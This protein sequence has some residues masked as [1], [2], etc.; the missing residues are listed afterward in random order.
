MSDKEK[1]EC[2]K[3]NLGH[4]FTFDFQ[5][6]LIQRA[7]CFDNT[8]EENLLKYYKLFLAE[9]Y[10]A[11]ERDTTCNKNTKNAIEDYLQEDEV[12]AEPNGITTYFGN[13][14][15][16]YKFWVSLMG[17]EAFEKIK[18]VMRSGE[19]TEAFM[20]DVKY[21]KIVRADYDDDDS[22]FYR[23]RYSKSRLKKA[24]MFHIPFK[25]AYR[26]KNQRF[27]LTGL[28]L[29]YLANTPQTVAYE[30]ESEQEECTFTDLYVS[31][32]KFCGNPEKKVLNMLDLRIQLTDSNHE[33]YNIYD[34]NSECQFK[35]YIERFILSCVCSFPA[36]HRNENFVEEYVIPQLVTQEVK[37]STKCDG[38]CYNSALHN[39][40]SCVNF[41]LFTQRSSDTGVDEELRRLFEITNPVT[42]RD[43]LPGCNGDSINSIECIESITQYYT[44]LNKEV[45]RSAHELSEKS[46]TKLDKQYAKI[47]EICTK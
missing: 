12:D 40:E 23:G 19:K 21:R 1:R 30:L 42:A 13:I 2:T 45:R 37:R 22:I 25:E 14:L 31:Q 7:Q 26:I 24:D 36:I 43:I 15:K 44:R 47:L 16:C 34:I 20:Y 5:K 28:P 10:I 46:R 29:L 11:R 6:T 35:K 8:F 33:N 18:D 17:E 27:S 41:V 3:K 39:E 4:F 9:F 32:Y 38:I